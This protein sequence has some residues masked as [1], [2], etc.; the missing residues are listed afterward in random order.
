MK[1]EGGK[2]GLTAL[3][4]TWLLHENYLIYWAKKDEEPKGMINIAN[5]TI[6]LIKN[7]VI[8]IRWDGKPNLDGICFKF[9][10]VT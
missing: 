9:I 10:S 1:K 8:E 7:N 3:Q 5:A 2:R 4:R 6:A